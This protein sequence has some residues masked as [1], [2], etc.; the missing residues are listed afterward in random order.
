LA[1]DAPPLTS[2]KRKGVEMIKE[3]GLSP[4]DE[5]KV[6]GENARTL[7]KLPIPVSS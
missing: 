1:P 6:Y 5:R 7:L 2:L 4:E 3:L